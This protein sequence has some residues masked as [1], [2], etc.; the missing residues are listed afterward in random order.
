MAHRFYTLD[1]FT[2]T[3]LAGN[4]LAVVTDADD[5]AAETM[6]AIA[7]EFGLS[8]TV[9]LL[10]AENAAHTA[11]AR[12]FTPVCELPF[13]GHPTVGAAVLLAV[14]R[15]G[16]TGEAERDALV[17]IEE[18]AGLIRAGVRLVAGAAPFA[19]F[20]VPFLPTSDGTVPPL[21]DLAHAVGLIAS[22][23]GCDNHRP[24]AAG[25][26]VPF[27]FVPVRDREALARSRLNRVFWDALFGSSPTG[28]VYLYC[29][30]PQEEGH[31]FRARMFAPGFGVAE[32]PA[33][34][35]AAAAFAAI[36][37]RYEPL[38]DGTHRIWIE[39]GY[40]MG[41]PSQIMLEVEMAGGALANARI[42]GHAVIVQEGTIRL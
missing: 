1:V 6:Q 11:R 20:D 3:A 12:I 39:Q 7:A 17:A 26:G 16:E 41:R 40:E 29:R 21:D 22:D 36:V 42:G 8:E 23:I 28:A 37:A 15:H 9:F 2:R 33:T 13:A 38:G 19:V 27:V 18:Q 10:V 5:L 24:L 14:L 30:D 4:P 25:V 32:D 31:D 35:A 34:G